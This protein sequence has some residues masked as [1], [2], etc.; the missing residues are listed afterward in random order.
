M[1]AFTRTLSNWTMN[2]AATALKAVIWAEKAVFFRTGVRGQVLR[3][4]CNESGRRLQK[5]LNKQHGTN[6]EYGYFKG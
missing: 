2:G 6:V 4:Y 3:W 5:A 1:K